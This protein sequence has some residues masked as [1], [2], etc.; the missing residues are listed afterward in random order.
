MYRVELVAGGVV[1]QAEDVVRHWPNASGD[2]TW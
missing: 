2:K 1:V